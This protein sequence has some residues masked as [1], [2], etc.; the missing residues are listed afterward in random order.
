MVMEFMA[1]GSLGDRIARTGRLPEAEAVEIITQVGEA[2]HHAHQ[3]GLIHRDVK[4]DN[5]LFTGDGEAKLTDLGLMKNLELDLNLT[6]PET[7][8]GTPNFIPPEQFNDAKHADVRCDIY[9]LAATLY[10]AVT[11]AWPFAAKTV[12]AVLKKKLMNE[13]IPP[14]QLVPT[15]SPRLDYAVRQAL[16]AD[17]AQRFASCEEFLKLLT[18]AATENPAAAPLS[19]PVAPQ[20]QLGAMP[21][22]VV[23]LKSKCQPLGEAKGWATSVIQ[24]ISVTGVRLLAERR[25]EPGT[26]LSIKLLDPKPGMPAVLLARVAHVTEEPAGQWILGCDLGRRLKEEEIRALRA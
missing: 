21:Q 4:P 25:F 19:P 8:I 14:R 24:D 15:L 5:I 12:T 11:G 3:Q 2:L 7:C 13:I 23:N 16:R 18:G 9:S 6:Q 10:M 1:G 20:P 26:T 17:P 22:F